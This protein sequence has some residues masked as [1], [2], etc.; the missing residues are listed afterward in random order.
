MQA[1]FVVFLFT[2]PLIF[3][4]LEVL[5]APWSV[6]FHI[7]VDESHRFSN[8]EAIDALD[9]FFEQAVGGTKEVRERHVLQAIALRFGITSGDT[10]GELWDAVAERGSKVEHT[11]PP[12]AW[13]PYNSYCPRFELVIRV[14]AAAGMLVVPPLFFFFI[15][16][17]TATKNH[18][19][20]ASIV[21][22]LVSVG[23]IVLWI[24]RTR[25]FVRMY[26]SLDWISSDRSYRISDVIDSY[27]D[28]P[29]HSAICAVVPLEVLPAE[30]CVMAGAYL[31][32]RLSIFDTD[33]VD[34]FQMNHNPQLRPECLAVFEPF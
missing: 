19:R 22:W 3:C 2:W 21:L 14:V 31:G 5:F 29:S 7:I 27:F 28:I 16:F 18:G 10:I 23:W 17:D 11:A 1:P 4:V 25:R 9:G 8:P 26:E 6:L 32:D 30:L 15:E 12:G 24:P 34:A 33:A 13:P 20:L